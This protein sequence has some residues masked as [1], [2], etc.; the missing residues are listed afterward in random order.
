MKNTVRSVL[1]KRRLT[2]RALIVFRKTRLL[3]FSYF[4]LPAEVKVP[5]DNDDRYVFFTTRNWATANTCKRRVK[6]GIL[7][8]EPNQRKVFSFISPR[9]NVFFDVGTQIGFYAILAAKLGVKKA[10]AFD[11]EN[12]YL[13]IAEKHAIHNKVI[14]KIDFICGAVGKGNDFIAVENYI[15]RKSAKTFSLDCFCQNRNLWPDFIKM[16]IEGFELG[17]LEGSREVLKRQPIIILGLHPE[18]IRGKGKSPEK[19]FHILLENGFAIISLT[20]NPGREVSG[21]NVE[22][23]L[24]E[25]TSD[26]VCIPEEHPL[27]R[28]IGYF[29]KDLKK[30]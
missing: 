23:F 6:D 8:Y 7:N 24:D 25:A 12:Q 20:Q 9:T 21:D 10:V 28:K 29:V 16:D 19:V 27:R 17:A 1:L 26:F 11:I 13:K 15:G 18:F 14:E 4:H 2:T 30:Y 3:L 22:D 5:L